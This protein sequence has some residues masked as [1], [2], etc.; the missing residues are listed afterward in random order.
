MM[1]TRVPAAADRRSVNR[2]VNGGDARRRWSGVIA[3]PTAVPN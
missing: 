1:D 2:Y 3:I